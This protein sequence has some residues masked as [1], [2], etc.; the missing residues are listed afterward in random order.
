MAI[1][2]DKNYKEIRDAAVQYRSVLNSFKTQVADPGN[3]TFDSLPL[4]V[5]MPKDDIKKL[6]DEPSGKCNKIAALLNVEGDHFTIALLCVD[7]KNKVLGSHLDGSLPGQE[8]WPQR[9]SLNDL[10]NFEKLFPPI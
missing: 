1:I 6:I 9:I 5:Y 4:V 8:T 7:D 10:I 2:N 3:I